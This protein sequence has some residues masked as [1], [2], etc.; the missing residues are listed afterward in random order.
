MSFLMQS[1]TGANASLGTDLLEKVE[2]L[3]SVLQAHNSI[4]FSD[5]Q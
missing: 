2:Q 4:I 1:M 3:F 5:K